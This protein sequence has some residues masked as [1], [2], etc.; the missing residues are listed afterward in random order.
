MSPQIIEQKVDIGADA[1]GRRV[2]ATRLRNYDGKIIWRI[3]SD[4]MSQR[5]EGERM[6]GLTDENIR[7]MIRALDLLVKP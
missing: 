2:T 7:Q 6:D 3:V 1:Y 4:A 5:D